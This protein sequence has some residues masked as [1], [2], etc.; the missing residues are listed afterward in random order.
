MTRA[1]GD[2]IAFIDSGMDIDPNGISMLLEHIEWYDADIIVGSKDTQ[3]QWCITH[4]LEGS[5]V[6]V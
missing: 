2:Y 5:T 3:R 4:L 6:C 1:K